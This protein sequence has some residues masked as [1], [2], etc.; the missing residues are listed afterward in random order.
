MSRYKYFSYFIFLLIIILCISV[1]IL[2]SC[3]KGIEN[4]INEPATYEKNSISQASETAQMEEISVEDLQEST[5]PETSLPPEDTVEETLPDTETVAETTAPKTTTTITA[6]TTAVSSAIQIII[7]N[8]IFQPNKTTI[9]INGT[10]TWINKD[11]YA[12]TVASN[13]GA[14][15]SGIITGGGQ[16]SFT[17]N[18]EGAYDYIC[19]IHPNMKG[20]IIVVK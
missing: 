12:H 10:V 20:T 14:F 19:E 8:D 13:S 17:P 6:E 7:V 16:F 2:P 18:K 9:K 5:V 4:T 15:N 1:F 3:S 11:G